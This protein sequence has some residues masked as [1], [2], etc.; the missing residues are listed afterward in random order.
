MDWAAFL[1]YV[2]VSCITPGPNTMISM[3]GGLQRGFR[4]TLR[5]SSGVFLGFLAVSLLAALA[6]ALLYGFLPAAEPWLLALGAAYILYL[7]W[8]VW[9]SSP[10]A[11]DGGGAYR[12]V[13]SGVAMQFINVKGVLFALTAMASYVLPHFREPLAIALIS[14]LMAACCFV[15]CCLWALFGSVFEGLYRRHT[16]AVNAVMALALA[17]CAV[18]LL[19]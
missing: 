19:L 10:D 11:P 16:K 13:L 2:L 1:S 14:T 8:R 4:Y 18:S 6:G 5:Y 12:G 9:R 3:S 7:A 17:F 15:C